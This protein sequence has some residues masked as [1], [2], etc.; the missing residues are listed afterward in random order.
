ME[1]MVYNAQEGANSL[2]LQSEIKSKEITRSAEDAKTNVHLS[3]LA[4]QDEGLMTWQ[5]ILGQ[6]EQDLIRVQ[7]EAT[8]ALETFTSKVEG[9]TTETHSKL[10]EMHHLTTDMHTKQRQFLKPLQIL[11]KGA[12]LLQGNERTKTKQS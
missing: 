3:F 11:F 1:H 6:F 7:G 10:Q 12:M 5:D 2:A 9:A 8:T 4:M